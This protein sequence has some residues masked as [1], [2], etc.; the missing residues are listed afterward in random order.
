LRGG[1]KKSA[2]FEGKQKARL[3]SGKV[4]YETGKKQRNQ[5]RG[6]IIQSNVKRDGL[7]EEGIGVVAEEKEKPFSISRKVKDVHSWPTKQEGGRG[8]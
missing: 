5:K 8:M 6:A 1:K 3:V 4:F 7:F 2:P